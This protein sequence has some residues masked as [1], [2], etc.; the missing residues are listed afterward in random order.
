MARRKLKS[1]LNRGRDGDSDSDE[2]VED[3][4]RFTHSDRDLGE[5]EWQ[6]RRAS[7]R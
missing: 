6:V 1:D 4:R 7:T 3:G 2:R 5:A